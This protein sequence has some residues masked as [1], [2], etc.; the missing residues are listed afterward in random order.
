MKAALAAA[1]AAAL[2]ALALAAYERAPRALDGQ[3][4]APAAPGP[5]TG[6]G[7]NGAP[8]R[9][10]YGAP[11]VLG[12]LED[13]SI[14]ESSGLA[15]SRLAPGL[16]WT[17][18]DANGDPVIYAFDRQGKSR[19]AWRVAG[20]TMDD[21][22]DIAAGP[23]PQG[24]PYLYVGD[25]GDNKGNRDRIIVYRFPEPAAG[26]AAG[27]TR[28]ATEAAESVAL[29]YPDGSQ[30][31]ETLMVHPRTGDIYVVTKVGFA[32]AGVYKLSAP[33]PFTGVHTLKRVGRLST[34]GVFGGLFTGGDI[35]PDGRRVVLCD[36]AGAYEL[37]LPA[38]VSDFDRV[39]AQPLKPVAVGERRQGEAISYSH[40]G[41]SILATSE[42]RP[43][44]LIEVT[45]ADPG[46]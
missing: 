19:G 39:W 9:A 44:P 43:T 15:A 13:K 3:K 8:A 7:Q 35:S 5:A 10:G 36:Y 30:D 29:K 27:D 26:E 18:N 6:A 20:A 21:W 38:G 32:A 16:F 31:A 17:H 41:S 40:D 33:Q 14:R 4:A 37:E 2:C 23:G 1:T 24:R 22:E 34:P 25:I 46:K 28:L 11:V 42:K 12:H 45:R